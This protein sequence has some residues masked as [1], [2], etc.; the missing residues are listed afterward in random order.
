MICGKCCDYIK[1][2]MFFYLQIIT[3]T[4]IYKKKDSM[5]ACT[6][7]S[8]TQNNSFI[9]N[10]EDYGQYYDTETNRFNHE[11]PPLE[12]LD[13]YNDA[14]EEYLDRYEQAMS[15]QDLQLNKIYHKNNSILTNIM[16][17]GFVIYV[18]QYIYNLCNFNK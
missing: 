3:S 6:I 9:Y 15:Y 14:Y 2:K 7:E 5:V 1:L 18:F 11:E 16:E 4:D 17:S 8:V 12:E 10:E 13:S